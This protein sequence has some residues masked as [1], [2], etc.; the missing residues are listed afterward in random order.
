MINN[1]RRINTNYRLYSRARY[2]GSVNYSDSIEAKSR[3]TIVRL[4][5]PLVSQSE[6]ISNGTVGTAANY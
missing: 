6:S 4:V 3:R 1:Y 2:V 5:E